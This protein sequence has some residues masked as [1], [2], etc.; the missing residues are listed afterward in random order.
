A[1][2]PGPAGAALIPDL[3]ETL[4]DVREDGTLYAFKVRKDARF[5]APLHRHITAADFKY[6]IERLYRVNSPG[7]SFYK[8]IVGVDDMLAGKDTAIAGLIA[9]GDSLYVRLS[10]RDPI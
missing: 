2:E 9:R 3:A 5:G 4:P 10:R 1:H 6:A 7:A 8:H